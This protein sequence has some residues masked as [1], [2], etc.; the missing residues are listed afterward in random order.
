MSM[1][2]ANIFIKGGEA[3][4]WLH[5]DHGGIQEWVLPK[6]QNLIQ[7]HPE[8]WKNVRSSA[9][10]LATELIKNPDVDLKIV[11]DDD[12]AD[13]TY[14]VNFTDDGC[15][16]EVLHIEDNSCGIVAHK[17]I[18]YSNDEL[19]KQKIRTFVLNTMYYGRSLDGR[20]GNFASCME[21][22]ADEC[23]DGIWTLIEN[24]K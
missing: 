11:S 13:L 7:N 6:L 4:V 5:M 20:A 24:M 16:V 10:E 17:V 12:T 22:I 1:T 15:D 19:T 14:C 8:W 21:G 23:A 3:K 2:S 9:Y 18:P